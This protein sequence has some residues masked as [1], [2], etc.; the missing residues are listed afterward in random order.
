MIVEEKLRDIR[1]VVWRDGRT[2]TWYKEVVERC[3]VSDPQAR[4]SAA[5]VLSALEKGHAGVCEVCVFVFVF[6]NAFTDLQCTRTF[7]LVSSFRLSSAKVSVRCRMDAT[8][9]LPVKP[10]TDIACCIRSSAHEVWHGYNEASV[11]EQSY[12]EF[13]MSNRKH[14]CMQPNP[15]PTSRPR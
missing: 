2:C 11:N 10:Y 6:R 12:D 5:E 4:P 1:P 14:L 7:K 8:R 9:P 3:L 13:P 15:S